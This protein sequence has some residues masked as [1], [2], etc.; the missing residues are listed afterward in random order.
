MILLLDG[1]TSLDFWR[2]VYPQERNLISA[3]V[4]PMNSPCASS[5]CDAWAMAP[6]WITKEYLARGSN[7]LG[8]LYRDGESTYRSTKTHRAREWKGE[9]P[10]EAFYPLNNGVYIS[11]PC[12][13]FLQM[14]RQLSFHQLIAYGDEICGLYGFDKDSS[15]GM[16][17][18]KEPRV[19]T[20]KLHRFL[21]AAYGQPGWKKAM[22]A[23]PYIIERSASPMET[24]DAMLLS[25]PCRYGG[26]SI[27]VPTMNAEVP[28]SPEARTLS[29][30]SKCYADI[31]WPPHK[32]DLEYQGHADHL[33]PSDFEA[34]RRRIN[35]LRIMGY[36]VIELTHGQIADWRSFEILAIHVAQVLG[37]RMRKRDLGSTKE[38]KQLRVDVLAW[39][40]AY[41]HPKKID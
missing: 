35:A 39:N 21:D 34:D 20:E 26:Y 29:W 25:L 23:L 30:L 9:F 15:R 27:A 24:L 3:G 16:I 6:S 5:A 1:N 37:Q 4:T 19:T 10:R 41:G 28:L 7:V 33:S 11:S 8:V 17:A 32:I 38:R 18:R 13:T 14:A 2:T 31:S 36:E 40:A 12:F 22:K